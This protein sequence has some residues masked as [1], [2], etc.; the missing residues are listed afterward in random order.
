MA[1]YEQTYRRYTGTLT[2]R[3]SRFLVL[4]RYAW[5]EVFGSRFFIAVFTVSFVPVLSL[6]VMLYLRANLAMLESLGAF[7]F[8]QQLAI[9]NQLFYVCLRIQGFFAFFL[10]LLA[11][12]GLVAPDLAHNALPLYLARPFKRWEY[13]L[14]K[15][16]VLLVLMS[17]VTW[18]PGLLLF[19]FQV[20]LG[21][22]EWLADHFRIGPAI[23]LGSWVW[24]LVLAL[25]GLALSAWVR[26]RTV[27]AGLLFAVFVVSRALGAIL[28]ASFDT[29]WGGLVDLRTLITVVWQGLFYGQV[30]E[31]TIPVWSAWLA[32]AAVCGFCLLLLRK[33]IRAYEIVR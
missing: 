21:G 32:L 1:V 6:A 3:W 30:R 9:D 25:F 13:V 4:S 18:V 14:G 2:P 26:W 23:F 8:V 24:I 33:K 19:L 20:Q 22:R 7:G 29:V 15:M 5:S 10:T 16:T 28:N 17:L 31:E 27:A 12:P 11:A